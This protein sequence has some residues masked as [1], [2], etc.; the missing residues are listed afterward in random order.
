MVDGDEHILVTYTVSD[1]YEVAC[2]PQSC[3]RKIKISSDCKQH[4]STRILD[5]IWR[6]WEPVEINRTGQRNSLSYTRYVNRANKD[7]SYPLPA[8]CSGNLHAI[9]V[10]FNCQS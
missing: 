5:A 7:L 4:T 9:G 10:S 8:R 6:A 1:V 3:F 2:Q